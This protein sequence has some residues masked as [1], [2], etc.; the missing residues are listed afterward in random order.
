VRQPYKTCHSHAKDF[1]EAEYGKMVAS[2]VFIDT[3]C[4]FLTQN[5]NGETVAF[6]LY[7]SI[8]DALLDIR[9]A[10]EYAARPLPRTCKSGDSD[11]TG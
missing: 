4:K 6:C 9:T 2:L 8:W 1:P 3:V 11:S 5:T 10:S 7:S